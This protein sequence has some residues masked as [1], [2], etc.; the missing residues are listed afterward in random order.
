MAHATAKRLSFSYDKAADVLYVSVGRPK[1]A[2]G[3]LLENGVIVRRDPKTD[4]VVGFTIVDFTRHFASR[5][6]Q[7]ITTPITAQLQ[8]V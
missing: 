3:E 5:N 7:P 6:A 8:P 4:Q 1:A 2:V